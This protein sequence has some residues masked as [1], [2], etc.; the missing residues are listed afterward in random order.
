[1]VREGEEDVDRL[2]DRQNA[3]SDASPARFAKYL[4]IFGGQVIDCGS[5]DRGE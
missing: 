1:M 5:I 2:G 4:A 3:I